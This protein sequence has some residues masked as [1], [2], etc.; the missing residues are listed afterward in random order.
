MLVIND[1]E[2]RELLDYELCMKVIVAVF[3]AVSSGEAI[4]PLR[5]MIKLP[6]V[7]GVMGWMPGRVRWSDSESALGVKLIAVMPVE[8]QARRTTH[9]G[10]VVLFDEIKGDII[11]VLEAGEIT[12]IRTSAAS[13]VAT[14]I[15]ARQNS[16]CLAILGSGL[17]AE[18]HI[19]A[20]LQVRSIKEVKVWNLNARNAELFSRDC[21]EKYKID[22]SAVE[23]VE[24]AVT[25]AD[26]V[27]TTTAAQDPIL[28][29]QWLDPG[30]HVNVIGSSIPTTA[31]IDVATVSNARFFVDHRNT[32]EMQGG[33]FQRAL[34]SGAIAKDHI[35]A[36]I[37]E[38][39]LKKDPGRQSENEITVYKSVGIVACDLVAAYVTFK[40]A[41]EK[42]VGTEVALLR[43]GT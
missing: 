39:L 9:H 10:V 16:T 6:D 13:A 38:I 40:L 41:Q 29:Y 34:K 18:K 20:V 2:V 17:Q 21:S 4:Q 26:I 27:C 30:T 11:A 22:V 15:L 1:Q 12:A 7:Q 8:G 36:E 3:K 19:E 23:S 32:V 42:K 28:K 33:E 43:S 14:D 37:G 5:Q 35:Q 24:D 31:E 25:G